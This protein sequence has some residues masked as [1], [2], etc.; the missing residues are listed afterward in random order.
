MKWEIAEKKFYACVPS[1]FYERIEKI[2]KNKLFW[3]SNK[4]NENESECALKS[5]RRMSEN[6]NKAHAKKNSFTYKYLVFIK[7]FSTVMK[8]FIG[9]KIY[10]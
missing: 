8:Y 2:C 1:A 5:E 9:R 7:L 3:E 10:I 6:E 4:T